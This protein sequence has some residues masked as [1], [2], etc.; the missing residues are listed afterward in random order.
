MSDTGSVVVS[1]AAGIARVV[2]SHPRSNSLPGKLLRDLAAAITTSGADA[3]V[4][5][6]IL[7][8]SGAKA[9][10][11]GASFEELLSV[12]NIEAAVHFFSGFALV[13][14]AMRTAPKIMLWRRVVLRFG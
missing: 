7:E 9:F 6:I 13:I 2:F 4:N 12:G 8:S 14:N 5:V 1:K 10:C 3:A 11:A